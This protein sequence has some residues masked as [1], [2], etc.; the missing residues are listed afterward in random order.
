VV[1]VIVKPVIYR[2]KYAQII[3]RVLRGQGS[4]RDQVC[5]YLERNDRSES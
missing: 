2:G 1:L 3:Y 5:W 4:P